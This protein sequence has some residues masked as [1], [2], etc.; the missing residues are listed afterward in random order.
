M[1]ALPSVLAVALAAYLIGS[2][3]FAYMIARAVTGQD[4]TTHGTGNVGAMNVRRTTGSWGWFAIA[5]FLDLL[6]GFVPVLVMPALIRSL[7]GAETLAAGARQ[8]AFAGAVIGHNYSAWMAIKK[9]A[10]TRTGKGL[11]AGAGALFAYDW[12]Y[13]VAVIVIGLLVIALTRYMMAGQVAGALALPTVALLLHS[14]DWPFALAMGLLVYSAHHKR[15]VGML[16]GEEPKLYIAD[17]MGP[18]G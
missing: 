3:P 2:I 5:M 16:R 10:F 12:R 15:F 8:V 11:A 14:T 17:R 7:G 6:K 9:R 4:I 1:S 18:R 13:A